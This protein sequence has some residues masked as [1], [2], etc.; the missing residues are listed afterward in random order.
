MEII[1][2]FGAR[3]E[4]SSPLNNTVQLGPG[5]TEGT[6]EMTANQPRIYFLKP[7]DTHVYWFDPS[8][9]GALE[10]SPNGGPLMT[11]PNSQA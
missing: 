6:R 7:R 9:W 4:R 2:V 1:F 8:S 3:G 11:A 5:I 10:R